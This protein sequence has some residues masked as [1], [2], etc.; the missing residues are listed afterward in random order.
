MRTATK[1]VAPLTDE[2]RLRLK[3]I[4][5]IDPNWRT[6]MRAQAILLSEKGF[7]LNQ[8][9][10]IFEIDRDSVSQ[11]LDW[12]ADYKLE[13]PSAHSQRLNVLGF[14]N[15]NG[16]FESYVFECPIDSEVLI[17]CFDDYCQRMKKPALIVLDNAPVHKSAA[18]ES[19][20]ESW[21]EQGLYL[22]FLPPYCPEINLI[23]VLWRKIKYEWLPVSAYQSFKGLSEALNEVLRGVGS[24]YRLSF[25][26]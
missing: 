18:F 22:L 6:R 25:A 17:M 16:S 13:I 10:T 8:L 3:E 1:F 11:W 7:A 20:I 24:K 26:H 12:W 5:K 4:H 23:E 21:G 15:L 19:R 14:L 9:A 2:E